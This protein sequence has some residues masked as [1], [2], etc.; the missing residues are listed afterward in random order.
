[1]SIKQRKN[2]TSAFEKLIKQAKP[3]VTTISQNFIGVAY[4]QW[5]IKRLL[6]N[7]ILRF[8]ITFVYKTRINSDIFAYSDLHAKYKS[9][10]KTWN[11]Y[12]SNVKNEYDL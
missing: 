7:S 3:F 9:L 1:M 2:A 5:N 6:S 8:I 11:I 10:I 12:F 4:R